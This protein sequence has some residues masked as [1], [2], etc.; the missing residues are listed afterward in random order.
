[1]CDEIFRSAWHHVM[2]ESDNFGHAFGKP[3]DCY[4]EPKIDFLGTD[5]MGIEH[6]VVRHQDMTGKRRMATWTM[7]RL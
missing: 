4:C 2:V 5:R 3:T 1:M 6:R 7:E